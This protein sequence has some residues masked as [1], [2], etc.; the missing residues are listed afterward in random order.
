M[1]LYKKPV[2]FKYV[3]IGGLLKEVA[4]F[5][6]IG[7]KCPCKAFV[8]DTVNSKNFLIFSSRDL[9]GAAKTGSGKTLAFLIPAIE[10]LF[11]LQFKP[12][13]GRSVCENIES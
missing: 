2:L 13:N 7:R 1:S 12:R 6:G 3:N 4:F 10:L 11:K 8:E 9:L 5:L